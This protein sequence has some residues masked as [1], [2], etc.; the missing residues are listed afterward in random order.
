MTSGSGCRQS[1][2]IVAVV[3]VT[4]NSAGVIGALL[5]SLRGAVGTLNH[6]TVVVDNGS[7]DGT[8]ELVRRRGDALVVEA[9]NL[10]F[11]AGI[12]TGVDALAG[13]GPI[14]VLNPDVRLGQGSVET[15]A[16][17]LPS[18]RT[19]IVVPRLRNGD[20]S[21]ARSLR[22]EPSIPRS[23]GMGDSHVPL[24]S[25]IV[26]SAEDYERMH[27][28]DWATG[29]VL[30][31]SRECF[32]TVG[33]FDEAF[34]MYSEETDFCLR[35]RDA[36]LLTVYVPQAAA[37][38]IGGGSG[39]NPDLY[40]MQVLNRVRL[41]RRRHSFGATLVLFALTVAREA[42]HALRG[43]NNSRRAIGALCRDA[44]KPSMLP[45]AGAPLRRSAS[46]RLR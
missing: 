32:D 34:F 37:A 20:G 15:L 13:S 35:A 9:P 4:Y 33:G 16:H 25:E 14:L 6:R 42:A 12:N 31:I 44:D 8:A 19:G 7:S 2:E 24:L 27:P 18:P 39:R 28:V 17:A 36:G 26:N 43:D 5:D 41:Y 1:Q 23:V 45:W 21:T 10:G 3:I 11:G 40:A 30:L 22:R 46:Q 38:H 29:A